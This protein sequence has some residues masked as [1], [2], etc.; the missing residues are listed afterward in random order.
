MNDESPAGS[1]RRFLAPSNIKPRRR[2]SM[3][4]SSKSGKGSG[5]GSADPTGGFAQATNDPDFTQVATS[6]CDNRA[7]VIYQRYVS[8]TI[9]SVSMGNFAESEIDRNLAMSKGAALCTEGQCAGPVVLQICGT[10]PTTGGNTDNK[11]EKVEFTVS[12]FKTD[13]YVFGSGAEATTQRTPGIEYFCP[14]IDTEA[15]LVLADSSCS[16]TGT[17]TG[18]CFLGTT[19]INDSEPESVTVPATGG[20][21]G[22]GSFIEVIPNLDGCATGFTATI[23]IECD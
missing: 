13:T 15:T 22:G 23:A 18:E 5:S 9:G 1:P 8:G 3:S 4:K 7:G 14:K 11:D 21:A 10:G 12:G 2:L 17:G 16:C 20:V 6:T 19:L